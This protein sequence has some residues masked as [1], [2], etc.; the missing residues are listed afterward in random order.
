VLGVQAQDLRAVL[1]VQA[2]DIRAAGLAAR[3]RAPGARPADLAAAG[4]VRTGTVRGAAHLV[5]AD[6]L[7]WIAALAG[8][9]NR[10]RCDARIEGSGRRRRVAFDWFGDRPSEAALAAEIEAAGAWLGIDLERAS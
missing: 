6:D 9:R 2:Q 3:A 1:G 7:P 5:A 10:R 8:P 4:L